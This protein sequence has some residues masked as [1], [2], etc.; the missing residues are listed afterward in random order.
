MAQYL[1][2]FETENE[3]T[4]AYTGENYNE[5]WVSYTEETEKVDY[6]KYDPYNGYGHVDLGLPS[7]TIWATCNVGASSPEGYGGFFAWGE[8]EPKSRYAG[9]SYIFSG[10]SDFTKYNS[11]DGK[12]V[13]D[14]EDDAAHVNMGGEW[15]MPTSAH[16]QEMFDNVT[17]SWTTLNGVSGVMYTST[18]NGNTIFFP[19]AGMQV[20][21]YREPSPT[22]T[23][24]SVWLSTLYPGEEYSANFLDGSV[25]RKTIDGQA[26][27]FGFPVRGI[28]PGSA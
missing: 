12:R 10:A 28:V 18:V 23:R 15:I 4:S 14:L 16:C 13:L 21:N 7:G 17:A 22:E 19:A 3:F 1:H 2:L 27:W 25:G 8:T 20:G 11:T 24:A 5:P 6:N 26:R 9:D